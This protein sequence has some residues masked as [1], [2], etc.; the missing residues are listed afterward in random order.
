MTIQGRIVNLSITHG[1]KEII[2]NIKTDIP[3]GAVI[4]IVGRNGEGKSSLLS[5]L[6]GEAPPLL[7]KSNG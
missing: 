2:K 6:S 3:L 7:D 1:H 5:V 4:G